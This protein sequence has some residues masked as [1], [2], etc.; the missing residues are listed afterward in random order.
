MTG[1][2]LYEFDDTRF[3]ITDDNTAE[4]KILFGVAEE[5]DEDGNVTAHALME[6][7]NYTVING[8]PYVWNPG[9]YGKKDWSGTATPTV[10]G[11]FGL[12]LG[13]KGLTLSTLFTYSLGSKVYDGI[14]AG[15]MGIGTNPSS[16]HEDNLKS[17]KEIPAG[18]KEDSANRIDPNGV[19]MLYTF[20]TYKM[21]GED[22]TISNNAGTSNRWLVS[23]NYLVVKNIVLSYELPKRLLTPLQ[24]QGLSISLACENL[25]TFAARKGL[26]PQYNFSGTTSS[27]DF[28]TARV[29]T[30]GI[31]VRF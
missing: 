18:M 2:S 22:V 10:Y 15:K 14:Y 1:L 4:G 3:Y 5:T 23:G 26:N 21:N 30:A 24:V 27:N 29:V 13:W 9:S 19:P 11:S 8:K 6:G 7:K 16:A 28:V 17:W 25:R 12:N 31:S 20:S